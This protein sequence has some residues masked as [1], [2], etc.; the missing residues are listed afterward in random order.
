MIENSS[1]M[2]A[3]ASELGTYM[4][5]IQI[6]DLEATEHLATISRSEAIIAGMK[7]RILSLEADIKTLRE[8]V[9]TFRKKTNGK[10]TTNG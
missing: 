9:V 10:N 4:I 6:A 3:L 5:N 1:L 8:E 7:D 2:R